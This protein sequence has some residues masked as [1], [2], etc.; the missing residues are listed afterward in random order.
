MMAK[1]VSNFVI[2]ISRLNARKGFTARCKKKARPTFPMIALS[3][4]QVG[5]RVFMVLTQEISW[6]EKIIDLM[7][8]LSKMVLLLSAFFSL[9]MLLELCDCYDGFN[10]SA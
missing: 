3:A 6:K 1:S 10:I 5:V 8:R 2:T 9:N 7:I 4:C